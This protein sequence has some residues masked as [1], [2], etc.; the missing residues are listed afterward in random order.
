MRSFVLLASAVTVLTGAL[1]TADVPAG[2]VPSS[3]SAARIRADVEFLADDLLEGREAGTRGYDLAAHYAVAQLKAAGFE[4]GADG[5]SYL[6][7]VPFLEVD[8]TAS[9]LRLRSGDGP[10]VDLAIP[11]E[12]I[13][14]ASAWQE[15]IEVTAPL[16]FAGYGVSAPE[17]NYDDYAGL[18]VEGRIVVVLYNAPDSLPSEPRA[19]YA[20][21]ERKLRTAA[22][23]GAVGLIVALSEAELQRYPWSLVKAS[24]KKP[25][26]VWVKPDGTPGTGERRIVGRATVN[27]DASA[28]LFAAAPTSFAEAV[29]A[30]RR[31]AAKGFA[32][33]ATATIRA[34]AAH[35]RIT[36]PNVLAVLP[37]SD[38]ELAKTSVV[39]TAH[40]DHTGLIPDG[41]GDRVNNGAYDNALG[42]AVLLEVARALGAGPRPKRTVVVAL[43]TAEE[44]GLLG[45]DYL[46]QNL[47]ASA[48]AV[49]ANVNLDMPVLLAPSRDL[50]AFG[51]ENS[52]LEAAV[53]AA[54]QAA[55]FTLSPDPMPEQNIFV[56]SDQYSFVKQGVPAVY[57]MPGFTAKDE[58]V[59]G[60]EVFGGFLARHYHKPSDD[61][62]LPMDPE[63]VA[64]FT[65]ANL[66]VTRAIADS[67]RAPEWKPGNFFGRM[68]GK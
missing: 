54:A 14:A 34:T 52:T 41:G 24:A 18:D 35:R 2:P 39:L 47:P 17:Q 3:V 13:V 20:S 55:G 53:R 57:L 51:A 60:A 16:V 59:N 30:A 61:L 32:L 27:P 7:Q 28:K 66:L 22:E 5:G 45:S 4:P 64:R 31:G 63:A 36:S 42:S 29:A 1:V 37:G 9:S 48:G 6:Q 11:D 44:K 40:L 23:R 38:P 26:L 49:V 50:V 33:N 65:H 8:A 56:R 67:P 21:T 25:G 43:V 19:Y 62:S 15:Q 12:A 68:F 10:E 46:A 58:K